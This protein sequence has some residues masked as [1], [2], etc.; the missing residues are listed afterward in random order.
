[1]TEPKLKLYNLLIFQKWIDSPKKTVRN[2]SRL[3]ML[4][5]QFGALHFKTE[6]SPPKWQARGTP[7]QNTTKLGH[8]TISFN[9]MNP[10]S[11]ERGNTENH[12]GSWFPWFQV[13]EFL[14]RI[15]IFVTSWCLWSHGKNPRWWVKIS[16]H[17]LQSCGIWSW[18]S[19][20]SSASWAVPSRSHLTPRVFFFQD[21]SGQTSRKHQHKWKT[22][23]WS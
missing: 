13:H 18:R 14:R 4:I 19:T 22:H 11:F 2:S 9:V 12:H 6:L 21:W 1:M 3:I 23:F 8:G 7:E 15:Q 10:F 16:Q 5:H 17:C 20:A